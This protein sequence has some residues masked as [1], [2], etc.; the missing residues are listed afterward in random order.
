MDLADTNT[1]HAQLQKY[2]EQCH[3]LDPLLEQL[4]APLSALLRTFAAE[5]SGANLASVQSISCLLW[6]I[7]T[8]RCGELQIAQGYLYVVSTHTVLWAMR[9]ST[10]LQ[11]GC[12]RGHKTVM[13]FF[14]NQAADLEPVLALLA[15]LNAEVHV[16]C[17][18]RYLK[19]RIRNS[20]ERVA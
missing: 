4:V 12:R 17:T 16:L 20:Q 19:Q 14:P 1:A 18:H 11:D 15:R 7:V 2:Q 9:G 5:E 10:T 8:V 13:R 6:T 3:L